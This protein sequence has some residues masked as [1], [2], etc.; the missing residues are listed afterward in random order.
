MGDTREG[1][2]Y[3]GTDSVKNKNQNRSCVNAQLL[4]SPSSLELKEERA[5]R[6][7]GG[8][9]CIFIN[10]ADSDQKVL[11]NGRKGST[12]GVPTNKTG[13]IWKRDSCELGVGCRGQQTTWPPQPAFTC[14]P[15][16]PEDPATST[17]RPDCALSLHHVTAEPQAWQGSLRNSV[18]RC[19]EPWTPRII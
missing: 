6:S 17:C 14:S 18:T 8:W 2:I 13:R 1:T 12:R 16:W 15:G 9:W 5:V 11:L 10:W 3:L 19:A 7:S 4:K